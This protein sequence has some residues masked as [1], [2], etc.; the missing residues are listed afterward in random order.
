[1]AASVRSRSRRLLRA[2]ADVGLRG[3][4][5][6]FSTRPAR[7]GRFGSVRVGSGSGFGSSLE[8]TR[9]SLCRP[10]LSSERSR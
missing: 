9:S 6:R 7:V 2:A 1:M 8:A 4:L 10:R 5:A 3:L